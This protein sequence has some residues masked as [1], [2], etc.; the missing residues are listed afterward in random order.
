MKKAE[1]KWGAKPIRF[2]LISAFV[3]AG[4]SAGQSHQIV[5]I[6]FWTLPE[7]YSTIH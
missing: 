4:S 5:T 6:C 3:I 2:A 7:E 1:E